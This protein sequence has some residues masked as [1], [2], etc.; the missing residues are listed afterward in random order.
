MCQDVGFSAFDK[1]ESIYGRERPVWLIV[2]CSGTYRRLK[3]SGTIWDKIVNDDG[4]RQRSKAFKRQL[5][6][7][8]YREAL[9]SRFKPVAKDERFNE[10]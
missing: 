6:Q 7:H 10:Y 8:D 9:R 4:K 1:R 2:E 3:C 5:E